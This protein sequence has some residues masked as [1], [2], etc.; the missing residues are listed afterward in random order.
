[1]EKREHLYN[2]IRVVRN[3]NWY[4]HY[5]KQYGVSTQKLKTELPYY[6]EIISLGILFRKNANT[7]LKRYMY[8]NAHRRTT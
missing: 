4:R 5:E 6:P 2:V 8:P 1:M 7:N 3:V